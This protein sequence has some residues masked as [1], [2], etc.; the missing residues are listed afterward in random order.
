MPRLLASPIAL[1]ALIALTSTSPLAHG[2]LPL[3]LWPMLDADGHLVGGATSY[4]L[5][6]LDDDG[7]ARWTPEES[8]GAEALWSHHAG[9][10]VVLVGT[11]SGVRV[12]RDQGCGWSALEGE[13][14]EAV[15]PGLARDPS[16]PDHLLAVTS[17][18]ALLES[19]DRGQRW[20]RLGAAEVPGALDQALIAAG[21]WWLVTTQETGEPALWRSDDRGAT[22][23][24]A[25]ATLPEAYQ[26]RLTA[27][28][29]TDGDTRL[30]LSAAQDEQLVLLSLDPEEDALT[31]VARLEGVAVVAFAEFA[32][33]LWVGV[34]GGKMFRSRTPDLA[35][36]FEL[37]VLG[38]TG[39]LDPFSDPRR[40]WG[41]GR[42][43]NGVHFLSSRDGE[44]FDG[45]VRYSQVCPAA[46]PEGSAGAALIPSL[47]PDVV[48]SGVG[49][50]G[51]APD[52][53]P[54]LDAPPLDDAPAPDGGGCGVASGA[55]RAPW[56]PIVAVGL[57]LTGWARRARS[58]T[59]R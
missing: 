59:A 18:K 23:R 48:A 2:G 25:L 19:H 36:G 50:P 4:G 14:G 8:L 47:W 3:G 46:C 42:Y 5:I 6:F 29:P 49:D 17:E 11:P 26:R 58:E 31:E 44:S 9:D 40:L 1:I 56:W 16:D 30:M 51:C 28:G 22:W 45:H 34:D 57:A 39:C 12:T 20:S 53:D 33:R 55:P 38:P 41:C 7:V 35:D 54:P 43:G 15:V 10:G 52:D 21:A 27:L 37:I 32:E 24:R 13:L